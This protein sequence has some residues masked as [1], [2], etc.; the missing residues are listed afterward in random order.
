MI[1]ALGFGLVFVLSA[2]GQNKTA[3]NPD[4]DCL[5]C[6]NNKDLKSEARATA[7]LSIRQSISPASM[8][9]SIAR[10]ATQT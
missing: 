6:H 5:A 7:F 4:E 2:S 8:P 9:R 10:S 1:A 3:A